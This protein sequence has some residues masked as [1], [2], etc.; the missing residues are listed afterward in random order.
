MTSH[1]CL[2]TSE[3]CFLSSSFHRWGQGVIAVVLLPLHCCLQGEMEV[4][5]F[6]SRQGLRDP[7]GLRAQPNP[8]RAMQNTQASHAEHP[9]L[10][11]TVSGP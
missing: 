4:L 3:R 6:S 5:N 11:G 9:T 2:H 8:G 1:N 7:V 10:L